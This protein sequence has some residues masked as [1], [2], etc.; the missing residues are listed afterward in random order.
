LEEKVDDEWVSQALSRAQKEPSRSG[1][2]FE[3]ITEQ[4]LTDDKNQRNTESGKIGDF[5]SKLYPIANLV[6]G[7]V[8]TAS[9]VDQ[10]L[11]VSLRF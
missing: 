6:L 3:M 7:T 1:G 4:L 9:S 5:M 2:Q 11:S 8:T 10:R